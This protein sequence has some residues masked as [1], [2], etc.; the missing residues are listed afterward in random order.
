MRIHPRP[1][2]AALAAAAALIGAA[3]ISGQQPAKLTW[4][5]GSTAKVEQ[6]IGDEDKQR[7]T[8]TL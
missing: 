6:L 3:A 4:I 2:R 1:V 7:H 8:R 5:P